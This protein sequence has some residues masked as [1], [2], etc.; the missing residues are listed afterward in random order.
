MPMKATH[1]HHYHHDHHGLYHHHP[2]HDH[3][4][5][6]DHHHHHH[7]DHPYHDHHDCSSPTGRE[8]MFP[9]L[10][11]WT[12]KNAR[13]S[14]FRCGNDHDDHEHY[15]NYHNYDHQSS[16]PRESP[17]SGVGIILENYLN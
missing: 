4:Y 16:R 15:N 3:H 2:N 14:H 7:H 6:H 8:L 17:I 10:F 9:L 5:H 12:G 13:V 1:L 11:R